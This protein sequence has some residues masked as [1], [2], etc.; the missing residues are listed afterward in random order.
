MLLNHIQLFVL[1]SQIII[2]QLSIT[3]Y[4]SRYYLTFYKLHGSFQ[5]N[6]KH[7]IFLL[8]Q[9]KLKLRK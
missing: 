7:F 4:L 1:F 6:I 3:Y 8:V 2:Y 9:W 5:K